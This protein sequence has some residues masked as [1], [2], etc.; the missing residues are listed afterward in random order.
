MKK[1]ILFVDDEPKILMALR[2]SLRRFRDQWDMVFAEG[3][4]AGLDECASAPFDVVVSDARMPGMEGSEFLNEVARL[5]PDTVRMILSGQC[6][7]NSVLKCVAVAHQFLS[8]PCDPEILKNVLQNVC[9]TRDHFHHSPHR[10]DVSRVQRLPSQRCIYKQLTDAMESPRVSTEE[11]AGI[12]VRDVGMTAKVMQLVSSGFFG[13]PQRVE[14]T[15][16]AAKFLGQEII[17]TLVDCSA[18]FELHREENAEED[19]R[20]LSDHCFAVSDSATEIAKTLT[21]DP[22]LIG[23]AHVAGMLHEIGVLALAG[24]TGDHREPLN[25]GD[26]CRKAVDFSNPVNPDREGG[27]DPGGYLVALWGLPDPVIQAVSYH[28]A[29]NCCPGDALAP[30]IA[31]HVANAL[32]EPCRKPRNG[33]TTY[34]KTDFLRKAGCADHL[35]IWR[36]ICEARQGEGVL[37]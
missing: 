23:D 34:L 16:E 24:R 19:L 4:A 21:N 30:L 1:R 36:N 13:S 32:L 8:K 31:V 28:R 26:N 14:N 33:T 18:V 6:S 9:E 22:R 37:Q 27:L 15:A 17:G 29:P 35:E 10:I 11:L 7:R 25:P 20:Q 5:Y 12:L 3:G 2:R